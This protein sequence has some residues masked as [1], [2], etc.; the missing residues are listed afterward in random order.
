MR[1]RA[2][3]LPLYAR[4]SERLLLLNS[5]YVRQVFRTPHRRLQRKRPQSHARCDRRKI[6]RRTH[7]AGHSPVHPAQKAAR[8]ARGDERI[9]IRGAHPRPGRPQPA[10]PLVHR[11]G[12]LPFGRPGRRRAQ[13]LRESRMVHLLYALPGRNITGP[14][15][16]ATELPDRRDLAHGHGDRQLLAARRGNRRRRGD[17]DDVLAALA[18]GRQG[19][20]QPALR[21]PQH[22]PADARPAAHAQRTVR[23]RT[24]HRRIRPVRIYRQGVRRDRA[25]PRRRRLR[26][27]LLGFHGRGAC[28]GRPGDRR[29][30]PAVAGPHESPRRMGRRH[31]RRFGTAPRKSDGLRR[32]RRRLP[33]HARGVQTQHAGPH[34]RRLGRPAGQPGPAHGAPDART[35][36]Q[37]RKSHLEHLYRLGPDGLH[38]GLLLCLQR[39]RRAEARR[40]NR[41]PGRRHRCPCAGGD[42]L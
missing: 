28:Q 11:H 36:H 20:P 29:R 35:A 21:R 18:R 34:H 19:G 3:Y 16:S 13:R 1:V 8:T 14:P 9:R 23:Y 17:G 12:L 39:P 15:R 24:H 42:G 26:A 40:R 7:R 30:R 38:D 31:R 4:V 32:S 25:I 33:D 6:D 27:R 10:L 37:T 2:N 22:L 5:S 41:P